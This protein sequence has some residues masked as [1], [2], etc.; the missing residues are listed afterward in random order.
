MIRAGGD[1]GTDRPLPPLTK[2]HDYT[3]LCELRVAQEVAE[4][5]RS[6]V[7][8]IRPSIPQGQSM[9]AFLAAF[10]QNVLRH[11]PEFIAKARSS[12]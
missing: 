3:D 4:K 5:E 7:R 10:E 9:E 1:G 6:A 11:E 12:C 8:V 2:T